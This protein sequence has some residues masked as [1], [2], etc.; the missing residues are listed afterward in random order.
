MFPVWK[1][2]KFFFSQNKR[3]D[4]LDHPP[5]PVRFRSLYMDL[6]PPRR[7]YFLNALCSSKKLPQESG[8]SAQDLTRKHLRFFRMIY[9]LHMIYS[10]FYNRYNKI[11][12][13][14]KSTSRSYPFVYYRVLLH[15]TMELIY[16]FMKTSTTPNWNNL[17]DARS[18]K[19]LSLPFQNDHCELNTIVLS[20]NK[21]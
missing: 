20:H 6:L 18:F 17:W 9:L 3:T 5:L 4:R 11:F 8:M 1:I 19:D 15:L 12:N 10:Y 7:T 13:K 16:K 14:K 21:T 2:W